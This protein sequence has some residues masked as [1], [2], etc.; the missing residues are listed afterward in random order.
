VRDATRNFY[1]LFALSQPV[2]TEGWARYYSRH[3]EESSA[4]RHAPGIAAYY[5]STAIGCENRSLIDIACGPGRFAEFFLQRGYMVVGLDLSEH[6]LKL[7]RE[8]TRR[9]LDSGRGRFVRADATSFVVEPQVGLATSL[10]NLINLFTDVDAVRNWFVRVRRSV[11]NGGTF[12]FDA[13]TRK[14]FWEGFNGIVVQ[15]TEEHLFLLR[16][17]YHGGSDAHSWVS[18]FEQN[19]DGQWERFQEKKVLTLFDPSTV[20]ALLH[21]TGWTNVHVTTPADPTTPVSD[22]SRHNLI[23]FIAS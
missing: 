8:R 19:E 9:F 22:P 5:E 7:A 17:I 20:L 1:H 10:G 2:E 12:V 15:E 6:M 23:L 11:I 16:G 3:F 14:G 13:H 4:L 21:E 18:G